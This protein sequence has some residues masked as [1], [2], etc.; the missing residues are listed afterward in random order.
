MNRLDALDTF[1]GVAVV[2]F[3]IVHVLYAGLNAQS[4]WFWGFY[5]SLFDFVGAPGFVFAAGVSLALAVHRKTQSLECT[6]P[7]DRRVQRDVWFS[8]IF[9]LLI[10]FAFNVVGRAGADGFFSFWAWFVLQSVAICRLL[11]YYSLKWSKLTRVVLALGIIA[12][13]PAT[14]KA[15]SGWAEA[16]EVGRVAYYVLYHPSYENTPIPFLAYALVGTVVGETACG[17]GSGKAPRPDPELRAILVKCGLILLLSAVWVGGLQLTTYDLGY[18]MVGVLNTNSSWNVTAIPMMFVRGS[19]ANV[20]YNLGM[21]C[22]F[23]GF[24]LSLQQR[25]QRSRPTFLKRYL[26]SLGSISLTVYLYHH[27]FVFLF[28]RTYDVL[29]VW[30]LGLPCF[31]AI[32]GWAYAWTN[33]LKRRGTVEWSMNKLRRFLFH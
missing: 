6:S 33:K 10:A 8:S 4:R 32:T 26:T 25:R 22:L 28:S 9:L 11:A 15:A 29:T 7:F 2:H 18:G 1:K 27:A 31:V 21:Q 5:Y 14:F 23:F 20:V 3:I 16:S 13:A 19:Y 17:K 24:L 30:T 12:I